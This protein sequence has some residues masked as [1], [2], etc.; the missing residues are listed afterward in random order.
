MR[1]E[2]CNLVFF[3]VWSAIIKSFQALHKHSHTII[4]ISEPCCACGVILSTPISSTQQRTVIAMIV[5][6]QY[7]VMHQTLHRNKTLLQQQTKEIKPCLFSTMLNYELIWISLIC[8][9]EQWYAPTVVQ[10]IRSRNVNCQCVAAV[11]Y[12]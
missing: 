4:S 7:H 2:Q 10:C 6:F 12:S 5:A 8:F 1:S 9:W 3:F 11:T